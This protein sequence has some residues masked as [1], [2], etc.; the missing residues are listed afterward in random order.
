MSE[1]EV[2][3][4]GHKRC[5]LT[6]KSSGTKIITDAPTDNFGKGESFS[7]TDLMSASLGACMLTIMGIQLEPLNIL[8]Q[9]SSC[10]IKKQ[11]STNPRRVNQIDVYLKM[12]S[13]IK[14]EDRPKVEEIART[15]PV[16]MSINPEIKI[17][18][19]IEYI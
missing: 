15:C 19:Q 11:M 2:N 3:Y 8:I 4:L 6:H 9:G 13:L 5:E 18:L 10:K 7:P 17:N 1:M 14:L 12:S 16:Q